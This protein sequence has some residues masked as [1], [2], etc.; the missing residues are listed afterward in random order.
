MKAIR[1]VCVILIAIHAIVAAPSRSEAASAAEIN[2]DATAT[3]HSFVRQIRG[4]RE[5]GSKAAGILVFSLCC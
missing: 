4:A 3:L 5:L 2:V 1:A